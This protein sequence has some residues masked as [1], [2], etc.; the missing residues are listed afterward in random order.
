MTYIQNGQIHELYSLARFV[1][2]R[3]P[4]LIR[5]GIP[6]Q[7]FFSETRRQKRSLASLNEYFDNAVA[8]KKNKL[9]NKIELLEMPIR[10]NQTM[11]Y[12]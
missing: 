11:F 6:T 3:A 10:I 4:L 2:I 5:F 12:L 1:Y 8:G 9:G 7:V